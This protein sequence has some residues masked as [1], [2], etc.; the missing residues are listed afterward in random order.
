MKESNKIK[1][2][3]H[4]LIAFLLFLCLF[5]APALAAPVNFHH[6]VKPAIDKQT[7][8]EH[9]RNEQIREAI[10]Q[11]FAN[12]KHK[13]TTNPRFFGKEGGLFILNFSFF[14][15]NGA[16]L[17]DRMAVKA[18]EA[19]RSVGT[20]GFFSK[21][22]QDERGFARIGKERND[23]WF[24]EIANNATRNPGSDKL[25]L[26]H[27]SRDGVSYQKVAAHYKASY[28]KVDDWKTI[29]KGLSQ[30]D[31]W[32]INETFLI[33]QLR[34]GKRILFSHNPLEARPG[35]FFKK[36]VSFLQELKY[37][38]IKRNEWTWEAVR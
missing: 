19:E 26:G 27:F 4:L 14:I 5:S 24:Q 11:S 30:D 10:H 36:E 15:Q 12:W 6:G 23:A 9:A 16:S 2:N 13:M 21:F 33:Q 32:R 18:A 38:F 22:L 1:P 8:L 34:Q 28:F 7:A 35:S 17:F 37:K 25:V 31:I 20:S 29:T 3:H